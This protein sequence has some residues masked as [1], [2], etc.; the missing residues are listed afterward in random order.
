MIRADRTDISLGAISRGVSGVQTIFR[1]LGRFLSHV[2]GMR[3]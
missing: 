2:W 1:I 3:L